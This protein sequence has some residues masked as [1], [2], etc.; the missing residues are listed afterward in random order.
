MWLVKMES[1]V[2]EF[3]K[4]LGRIGEPGQ[5]PGECMNI[6]KCMHQ[7]KHEVPCESDAVGKEFKSLTTRICIVAT[8]NEYNSMKS[9]MLQ[10]GALVPGITSW[11]KWWD[12]RRF[13]L[14]FPGFSGY[15]IHVYKVLVAILNWGYKLYSAAV[16]TLGSPKNCAVNICKI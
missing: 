3:L 9:H 4:N 12:A 11:C 15:T 2:Q 13:D 14:S 1:T 7:Q 5:W 16:L 10:Q 8:V 6:K